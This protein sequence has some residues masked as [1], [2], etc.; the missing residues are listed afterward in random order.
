M[1]EI[2][3]DIPKPIMF[4][5]WVEAADR[6]TYAQIETS[7]RRIDRAADDGNVL[8]VIVNEGIKDLTILSSEFMFH[9]LHQILDGEGDLVKRRIAQEAV[10]AVA[11]PPV[12]LSSMLLNVFRAFRN[13]GF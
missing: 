2:G 8:G 13:I 1:T 7:F 4:R 5:R 6:F 9:P 10:I 3:P 11:A 12:F